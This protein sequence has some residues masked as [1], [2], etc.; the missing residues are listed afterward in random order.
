MDLSAY[1]NFA[2]V[3]NTNGTL[4]LVDNSNYPAGIS[5]VIK[6]CFTAILQP[7]G[8]SV[9]NSNF[10]APD[11]QWTGSGL[12]PANYE[13]RLN[14]AG[15][16][17]KGGY[18]ITYQVQAPG[19]T[20]TT[21]IKTFNLAYQRPT[22]VI[23]PS[24][25]NFTP[26]LSVSDGSVYA[27][28]G[29]NLASVTRAW[30]ALIDS[31]NGTSQTITSSASTFDLAYLGSYYDANYSVSLT[32]IVTWN[33]SGTNAWVALVDTIILAA[34]SFDSET[35]PSILALLGYATFLLAQ[36]QSSLCDC[37]TYPILLARYLQYMAVYTHLKDRGCANDFAGLDSYVYLLQK[38]ANNGVTPPVMHT[39]LPI[40][41]Y[42]FG[43]GGSGS[44]EWNNI[45]NKPSTVIITWTVGDAGFPGNGANVLTD[46]RL[47]GYRTL[48]LRNNIQELN[49][50]KNLA[51][52][53]LTFAN[54][55]S[56]G[57]VI[58]CQSIPL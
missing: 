27:Q 45:L 53:F 42:D 54:A 58:Y 25:N 46:T 39:D 41:A 37:N 8:I 7:D 57:E 56:T 3:M 30:S 21:L 43:C 10:S 23:L 5:P 44:V 48:V 52:D 4:V 47:A 16:F 28:S 18:S 17:Q 51:D 35:P 14:T 40:P 50:T 20:P 11:I 6:G 49:Y 19:Y 38:I 1:I 13:L 9:G 36:V 33:L 2:I 32:S 24:F 12:N 26:N 29:M 31:V 55:F 15:S 34:Q 22:L